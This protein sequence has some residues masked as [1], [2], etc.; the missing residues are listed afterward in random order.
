[1]EKQDDVISVVIDD[2][3]FNLKGLKLGHKGGIE[4]YLMATLI[5]HGH[6]RAVSAKAI[7]AQD[8]VTSNDAGEDVYYNIHEKMPFGNRNDMVDTQNERFALSEANRILVHGMLHRM[9]LAGKKVRLVTTSP[10]RRFFH[11]NGE[12]NT[13]YI[14]AR[15]EN[16]MKPVIKT[17]GQQVE[18]VECQ[19]CPEGFASFLSMLF[20]YQENGSRSVI[21]LNQ[22]ISTKDVLMLDFGGQTLNAVVVSNSMLQTES[23]F[24]EE[25]MGSLRIYEQLYDKAKTYRQNI[26]RNEL[27][28]IIETGEFYSDK[29]KTHHIDLSDEVIK[30]V[31]SVIVPGMEKVSK[32][33]PFQNFDHIFACGGTSKL[34]AKEL[35]NIDARIEFLEEPLYSNALGAMYNMLREG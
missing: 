15:N 23:S 29:Q 4:R 28:K 30:I 10:M 22:D 2:G 20:Q 24:S 12:M 6:G 19:Q 33:M 35:K 7:D 25:G 18:V 17:D 5:Q 14:N 21:G 9:G 8:Y 27:G 13:H 32:R 16:L 31:R 3:H 1:M 26:S 11:S 34:I